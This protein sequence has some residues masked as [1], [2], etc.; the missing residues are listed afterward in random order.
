MKEQIDSV[1]TTLRQ[2]FDDSRTQVFDVQ[3]SVQDNQRLLLTGRVLDELT[4]QSLHHALQNAFPDHERIDSSLKV[5]RH[6]NPEYLWVASN[7]TSLHSGTSFLSE[8]TSQMLYGTRVEVLQTHDRW[9]FVRQDDGYL[10][11]TYRPY[12]NEHEPL[13][14]THWVIHPAS[15]LR[16]KPDKASAVLTRV[17][18]GSAVSVTAVDGDWVQIS[19]NQ[20]GWLQK[21][22][23]RAFTELPVSNS[24][25]RDMMLLDGRSLVGV[26]YLWGGT[27][28]N[29]IDCSGLAQLLH[30]W[31]GIIIPRDADMQYLQGIRIEPPFLP[32]DLLFFGEPGSS[33]NITHVAVSL[34]DW[35]ILHSS[36]SRN[37]IYIDNVQSVDHLRQSYYGACSYL[38]E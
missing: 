26:P 17:F 3:V 9:V 38:V 18:G 6:S 15:R 29:G 16:E 10:G 4:Y 25:K 19:A 31:V 27:S 11:W 2:Q 5:L 35:N 33:R 14:P 13:P 37:G 7:L 22:Q 34:G 12:L 32:G 28:P 24:E 8:M 21:K 1:L 20:V 23:L 30:R 36:R